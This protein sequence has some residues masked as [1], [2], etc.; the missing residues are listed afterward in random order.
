MICVP[1]LLLISL[2]LS[3]NNLDALNQMIQLS[4]KVFRLTYTSISLHLY[5]LDHHTPL[6]FL[7][8][9]IFVQIP[10]S[11]GF[12]LYA[13]IVLFYLLSFVQIIGKS[14]FLSISKVN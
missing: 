4:R 12:V 7:V 1:S 11:K 5:H 10:V 14:P 8:I 9:E 3:S 13:S 2:D 6:L